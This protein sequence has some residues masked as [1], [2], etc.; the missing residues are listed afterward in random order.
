MLEIV[1]F[2]LCREDS[3]PKI[4]FFYLR[5]A[6]PIESTSEDK[7]SDSDIV[8]RRREKLLKYCK[9]PAV[10]FRGKNRTNAFAVAFRKSDLV[11]ARFEGKIRGSQ[12]RD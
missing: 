8:R 7:G 2:E 1:G 3:S 10:A 6:I 5:K 9:E 4:D 12:L 11:R